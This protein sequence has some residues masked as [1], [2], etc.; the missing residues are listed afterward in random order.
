MKKSLLSLGLGAILL[1]STACTGASAGEEARLTDLLVDTI[2]MTSDAMASVTDMANL[3]FTTMSA[4]EI[5]AKQDEI[6]Q[7]GE[8]MESKVMALPEKHGFESQN[9][10]EDAFTN[11]SDKEAFR[12]K[13]VE[14][15]KAKC[16]PSQDILDGMMNE[17]N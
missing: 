5:Q 13:V 4:E 15:T 2:C 8:E 7:M 12:N 6:T 14:A 10:A 11:I 1:T 3:D 16:T 9:A 17:L